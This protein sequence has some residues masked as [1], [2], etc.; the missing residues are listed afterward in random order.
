MIKVSKNE[1]KYYF[2]ADDAGFVIGFDEIKDSSVEGGY[3]GVTFWR[4][5]CYLFHASFDVAVSASE[6]FTALGGCIEP[7]QTEVVV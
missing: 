1:G 7:L 6:Q 2:M 3:V 4:D 5:G